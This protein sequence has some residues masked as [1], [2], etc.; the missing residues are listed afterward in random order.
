MGADL[1]LFWLEQWL[2]PGMIRPRNRATV[3]LRESSCLLTFPLRSLEQRLAGCGWGLDRRNG[4]SCS[5]TPLACPQHGSF[6]RG[7]YRSHN[8]NLSKGGVFEMEM[9]MFRT[10][11]AETGV[12]MLDDATIEAQT[13]RRNQ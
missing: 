2:A 3:L 13:T 8:E 10:L 9:V 11:A 5:S 1:C 4:L 6:L 12:D 7:Q